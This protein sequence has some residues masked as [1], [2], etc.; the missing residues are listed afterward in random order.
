M[1]L[2][3]GL[4]NVPPVH[5]LMHN[6][7]D[8]LSYMAKNSPTKS[9]E[10]KCWWLKENKSFRFSLVTALFLLPVLLIP[11]TESFGHW[12]VASNVWRMDL[13]LCLPHA[14]DTAPQ[15]CKLERYH[16]SSACACII[17]GRNRLALFLVM[18]IPL[19]HSFFEYHMEE[20]ANIRRIF[21]DICLLPTTKMTKLKEWRPPRRIY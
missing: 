15:P 4:W 5:R 21:P 18:Q 13:H 3:S 12:F 14:P 10:L 8:V 11:Q 2:V 20:P 19:G 9:R 16:P 6:D 1:I 17:A 7:K